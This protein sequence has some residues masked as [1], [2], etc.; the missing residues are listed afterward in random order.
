MGD[1]KACQELKTTGLHYI[2]S[3]SHPDLNYL[4]G[5]KVNLLKLPTPRFHPK[6]ASVGLR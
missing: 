6:I 4:R 5:T 2:R 1:D 3:P